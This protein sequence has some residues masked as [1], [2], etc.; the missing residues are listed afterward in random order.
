MI[1]TMKRRSWKELP[2]NW[3]WSRKQMIAWRHRIWAWNPWCR[4]YTSSLSIGTHGLASR[5]IWCSLPGVCL[6]WVSSRYLNAHAK[7]LK[8]K[9]G[10]NVLELIQLKNSN[11]LQISKLTTKN[12]KDQVKKK[13]QFSTRDCWA[14]SITY[15]KNSC[16]WIICLMQRQ[17]SLSMKVRQY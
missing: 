13:N 9:K 14:Y 12:I 2:G 11:I 16:K 5:T 17:A 1:T 6:P 8:R 4:R 3:G 10:K 15:L 7:E